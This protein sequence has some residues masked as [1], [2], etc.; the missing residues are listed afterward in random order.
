MSYLDTRELDKELDTL[1]GR[2]DD[3]D[4][5]LDDEDTDRLEA[6]QGLECEL[7][8]SLLLDDTTMIPEEDFEDYAR[9]LAEDVGC[10][11]RSDEN[12]LMRY[13]DWGWWAEDLKQDYLD[14][15]FEGRDYLIRSC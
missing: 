4:D 12:P 3:P 9:Q 14:V 1:K 15:E 2:R 10:C 11:A 6:L 7:G 13:I 8:G 5:E